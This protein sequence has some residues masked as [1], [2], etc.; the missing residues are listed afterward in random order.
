MKFCK[1]CGIEKPLTDYG[2]LRGKQRGTCKLCINIKV[3]EWRKDNKASIKATYEK[4]KDKY[5]AD[6]KKWFLENSKHRKEYDRQRLKTKRAEY[7]ER[8]ARRRALKLK[9]TPGWLTAED[10]QTFKD[11]YLE[12]GYFGYHVDHIIPLKSK[13]VCGLHVP[14]NLQILPPFENLSKNNTFEVV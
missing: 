12:A 11:I 9:A 6:N 10:K 2:Y 5:L 14:A 1:S 3:A 7:L 8:A 13:V 4:H